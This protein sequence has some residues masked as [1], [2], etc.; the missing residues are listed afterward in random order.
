MW[1]QTYRRNRTSSNRNDSRI[2]DALKMVPVECVLQRFVRGL[3]TVRYLVKHQGLTSAPSA[4]YLSILSRNYRSDRSLNSSLGIQ[5]RGGHRKTA[6]IRVLDVRSGCIALTPS[7]SLKKSIKMGNIK[8]PSL[9]H[10]SV[11]FFL[12]SAC[13]IGL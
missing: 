2:S 11:P 7:H 8:Y 5:R 10:L 12:P 4:R 3:W 6:A 1:R 13:G 9:L